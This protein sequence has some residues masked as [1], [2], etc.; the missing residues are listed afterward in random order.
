VQLFEPFCLMTTLITKNS[1][2][3]LKR[4]FERHYRFYRSHHRT[5]GC[6]VTHM[7]GIPMIVVSV[8]LLPYN[9]KACAGLQIGG[10]ILQ[11]IG[12]FVFEHNKP[13]LLE[14]RDP[15]TLVA[16][17]AFVGKLWKSVLSRHH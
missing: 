4:S 10:W 1:N 11:F 7:I 2:N 8:F 9:K 12:H 17:L 16:A 15:M 5:V 3:A 13:V 14:M 6:R